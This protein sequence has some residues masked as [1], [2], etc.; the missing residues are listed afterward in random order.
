MRLT[1]WHNDPVSDP[2]SD[3]V[4]LHDEFTGDTWCATP[5]PIRTS[6]PYRVV[7]SAGQTTFE[8]ERHGIAT[9]YTVGMAEGTAVKVGYLRLTNNTGSPRRVVVTT[10]VEW[11]LGALRER[12]QH[13]V[14]NWYE[15]ERST[16]FAQNTFDPHFAQWTAF[17][18]ITDIASEHT[19]SRH[20]FLGRNGNTAAPAALAQHSV[21]S[22]VTGAGID[23]C[24]ALRCV[25]ELAPGASYEL[26][27][28]LGA[29][30]NEA[31]AREAVVALRTVGAIRNAL[32][33]TST[34]WTQRLS[35]VTV[36]TPDANF[37]A[38]INRWSLY[39]ALSC[40][41][42]G[43]SALYQSSGAYGFR[44]QLQDVMAFVYVN[45][46]LAREHI[47]RASCRQFLEGDVQHWWHPHTGRGVRTRFS[48]DLVWLPYVTAH[49]VTSTGDRTVLDEFVP[50]LSMRTLAP[51]EHEVYDLPLV[52]D[53]HASV[54]EHCLR[55]LRRACT[56]GEHGLPLIGGGDWNDGM[57][58]VGVDGRGE[59]VWLA[60]FL[61]ST[62]RS[63]ALVAEERGDVAAV[64]E[65]RT[66]AD[67]YNNAVEAHGWDGEWYR[68]AYFDD[69]TPLGSHTNDECTI[70]SIAQSWS[71]ISGAGDPERQAIAM[72]SLEHHLVREDDRLLV[73]LT[74]PFDKSAHDPG[75]IKGYLP[76]V[77]EN[78]AQYTHAALW[79]VLATAM[80]GDGDRAFEQ[81]QM[82]NPLSHAA[83]PADVET[84]KVEPYVVAADVYTAEGQ[85]GRG[86]WTWYTGSASWMYRVG[87]EGILGFEKRADQLFIVPRAPTSWT[88]YNIR[89]RYGSTDYD[90]TVRHVAGHP[91]GASRIVIDGVHTEGESIPLRDDGVA[92]VVLVHHSAL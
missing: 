11:V 13:Q 44:D 50:F 23:P 84:Y 90:I 55:A 49:Y 59:S 39:Q 28:L 30:S 82:I 85:V 92:H 86:G 74:P 25:I 18:A 47:L 43:R 81:F 63:F 10:Y 24:A 45:A 79:A 29:A 51:D 87:L 83:T 78:G 70:D 53:E 89:Y 1:P 35:A 19:G 64:T 7:H 68:R 48:D 32:E 56:Y 88:E 3:V 46:P 71:V 2:V 42:W 26:G 60:W 61:I 40:R 62:L 34:A 6:T 54:Y 4:Y 8:H 5:A 76:G 73:L 31:S 37:D 27:T 65:M 77:R 72:R 69:G 12:G 15:K 57:N 36:R 41:M 80:R 21:L 91:R 58:R 17:H 67:A 33:R 22:G 16:M 66:H 52:T 14:R 38:M 9:E 75:Y 20:T